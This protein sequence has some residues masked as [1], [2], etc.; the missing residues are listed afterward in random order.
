MNDKQLKRLARVN[1]WI[2]HRNG[3]SHEIW[4]RG[5]TEQITIPYRTRSPYSI[6]NIVKQLT[7]A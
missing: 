6:K 5:D 1:G 2:K 7:A 3:G 4:R